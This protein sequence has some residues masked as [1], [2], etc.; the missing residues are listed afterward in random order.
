MEEVEIPSFFVCPISL[1]LMKDPI[2]VPTGITYD[3][4]SIEKWFFSVKKSTCP[5]TKQAIPD[6]ELTPNHTLRRLIQS[7]C[8]LN[9]AHGIER[10]PTPRSPIS[11]S[12]IAKLLR[13]AKSPEMQNK[14]L[15]RLRSIATEN[16]T[17]RCCMEAAGA[18]DFLA[19]LV[20]NET[21]A[22]NCGSLEVTSRP[23]D[24]ALALLYHLQLSEASLK[25]LI[26][27]GGVFVDSLTRIMQS[28]TCD[29]RAYAVM[30]L[31][32]MFEVADIIQLSSL[33]MEL[34]VEVV[35]LLRDQ[36]SQKATKSAL[37]LLIRACQMGRNRVKAGEASAV[38]VLIDLLLDSRNE[39]QSEMI[40]MLLDVL[41]QCAEGR[42]ELLEHGAG[43][44]IVSKKILRVSETASE[45]GVR[46]LLSISK[47]S[48]TP[49][50]V[51]E[52]LQ[53]GVA[54][55]LCLVL[56]VEGTSKTKEKAREILKLHARAWKSSP[57]I[58]AEFLSFYPA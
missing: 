35:R 51:Q 14:C 41:C 58:P 16:A 55:K 47:F 25:N 22:S 30:L 56:Q 12:Q 29:S 32:S 39:W 1:Q 33:R 44:T 34:F 15:K 19:A 10:I 43:I 27:D 26:S 20:K 28:G 45:R 42:A 21:S 7:W 17:N 4:E 40:L 57:C 23:L 36:V 37:K 24:E 5:V 2:T 31:K 3:R 9:A 38:P 50:I 53:V 54:A 46:I 52:M 6:C 18:A 8:T 48:A 13:E 11:K 49:S